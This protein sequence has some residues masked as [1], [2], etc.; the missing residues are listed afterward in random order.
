LNDSTRFDP[1]AKQILE[2]LYDKSVTRDLTIPKA[3][4]QNCC[5]A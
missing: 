5:L 1:P 2:D 4:H 3:Y